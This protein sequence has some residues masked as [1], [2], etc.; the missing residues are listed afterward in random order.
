MLPVALPLYHSLK[1]FSP[2]GFCACKTS[3][4]FAVSVSLLHLVF[5][6]GSAVIG[7]ENR[8]EAFAGPWTVASVMEEAELE[9]G[10]EGDPGVWMC[11][12]GQGGLEEGLCMCLH[13][14]SHRLVI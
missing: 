1:T 13:C 2:T 8:A 14:A 9:M 12:G 11:A 10:E 3:D 7:M 5:G 6:T 4:I